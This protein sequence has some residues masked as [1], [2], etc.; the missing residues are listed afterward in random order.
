MV[1][2]TPRLILVILIQSTK[3]QKIT[4]KTKI[5]REKIRK[6]QGFEG[7]HNPEVVGSSPASATIKEPGIDTK[8]VPGLFFICW[9]I[10]VCFGD[11]PF[12][13]ALKY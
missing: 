6:T 2:L 11:I 13:F 4:V 3:H 10:S 7:P 12:I 5:K 8:S 1:L 9:D